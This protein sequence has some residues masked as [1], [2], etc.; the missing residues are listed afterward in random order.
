MQIGPLDIPE[1]LLTALE[2]NRLVVFAGAGVSIPSPS[3]L[4]SFPGLVEKILGRTLR[5][6][7]EGQLDRVLGRSRDRGT[8][9]HRRAAELLSEP[10]SSFNS[11]HTSLVRLFGTAS[12]IRIV[13]TNFD[14]HFEGAIQASADLDRV[15]I[16]NAPA[17]PIG[18]SFK[19]LVH[20]HGALERAPE[21]LVLT[22]ADFGRA[23][24]TEGWAGRFVVELFREFT[25][26]FVG[27]SYGDTVMSYLTRGLAPTMGRQRFALTETGERD[28]WDLLGIQAI[29]YDPADHRR[30]IG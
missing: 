4:S 2:E 17:L 1:E 24:L 29:E 18:S 20:L 27:Y 10:E 8:P 6:D 15:E 21:E 14:L 28:K 30:V 23:Y 22:D 16:Y 3:S 13:T 26:L 11:L 12:A 25:V 7:E 19:G 9:V 5:K